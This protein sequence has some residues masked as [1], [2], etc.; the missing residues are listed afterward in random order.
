[1]AGNEGRWFSIDKSYGNIYTKKR[2]DR[3]ERDHYDLKIKT[4][5]DPNF[6]IVKKVCSTNNNPNT[7]GT[8]CIEQPQPDYDSADDASIVMV[9]IFIDDKNDNLPNFETSEYYVG[10]PYDAKVGDLILDVKAYDPD[11]EGNGHLSYAILR[12]ELYPSGSTISAGSL[13]QDPSPFSMTQNGRLVLGSLMAE[14]NQDR[15]VL[16]IEAIEAESNHRAKARVNLW[17]YEP[18]QL[19]KL[20]IDK[21]PMEVNKNKSAII[22]ELKNVTGEIVVVDEIRYHIDKNEGLKRQ[23]TDMYV[24]VVQEDTNTI[25]EPEEILKLVDANVDY[26]V[27]YYEQAGIRKIVLAEESR[28]GEESD[29]DPNLA[30]LIALLLVLF[31]GIVMFSLMCCCVKSWVFAAASS[32]QNKPQKLQQEPSPHLDARAMSALGGAGIYNSPTSLLDDG[33]ISGGGGAGVS[34]GTDNPLWIDQ[35]YKAYEEQELT[36]TVFSDQDNSVISGNG[37]N[38]SQS[39]APGMYKLWVNR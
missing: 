38:G 12:S 28:Q 14:F 1:M 6:G 4:S 8:T 21:T 31:L 19:I 2:L 15:F 39:H 36:M 7:I 5:N 29:F 25:I 13:V 18:E 20:V 27:Q 32:A 35:K 3:E 10:I 26:L 30:A 33:P 9:Q 24:H 37:V 11:L 23:M 16:D 22:S 17:I 34:G